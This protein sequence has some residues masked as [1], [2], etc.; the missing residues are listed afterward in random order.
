M[1]DLFKFQG[2]ETLCSILQQL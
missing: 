1:H 2:L